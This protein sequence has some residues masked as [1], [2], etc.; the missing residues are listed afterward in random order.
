[1]HSEWPFK[2]ARHYDDSNVHRWKEPKPFKKPNPSG[3]GENGTKFVPTDTDT[4]VLMNELL[5]QHNYNMLASDMISLHRSLPDARSDECRSLSYPSKLPT[6]SVIIIF[7]NEGWSTLLRTIWSVINR[8]PRELVKEIILVDDYS[9]WEHLKRQL[10]DYVELLPVQIK[11]IR[12][13]K[14]VGL[15]RARLIGAK[16]ATVIDCHFQCIS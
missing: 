12:T 14:R 13:P 8:S 11:V 15:I 2:I 9:T 16:H 7:H 1:M 6:A 5:Q 3:I 10:D 4:K